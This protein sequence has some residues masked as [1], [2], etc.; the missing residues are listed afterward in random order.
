MNVGFSDAK[1]IQ[2]YLLEW[3]IKLTTI[4]MLYSH[5]P[6]NSVYSHLSATLTQ[7]LTKIMKETEFMGKKSP[8]WV[9]AIIL[10]TPMGSWNDDGTL[11]APTGTIPTWQFRTL[12]TWESSLAFEANW[13]QFCLKCPISWYWKPPWYWKHFTSSCLLLSW[14]LHVKGSRWVNPKSSSVD[15]SWTSSSFCNPWYGP[16]QIYLLHWLLITLS[17][18]VLSPQHSLLAICNMQQLLHPLLIN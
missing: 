12:S 18:D 17:T 9:P 5:F 16:I 6:Q 10:P 3:E 4:T 14:V 1:V 13:R 2:V 7:S 11:S 15:T 8:V